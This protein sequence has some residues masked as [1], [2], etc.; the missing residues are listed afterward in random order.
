[1]QAKF[2]IPHTLC[3]RQS[4][5]EDAGRLINENTHAAAPIALRTSTAF[6]TASSREA[7]N[8]K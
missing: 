1:L 6:F 8:G 4:L 2:R 7:S 3:A 5:G